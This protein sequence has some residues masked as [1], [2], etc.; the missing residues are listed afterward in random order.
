MEHFVLGTLWLL[1]C[2]GSCCAFVVVHLSFFYFGD[3][4]L[5][6]LWGCFFTLFSHLVSSLTL[7]LVLCSLV[8]ALFIL[9][10]ASNGTFILL[11]NIFLLILL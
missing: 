4:E 7:L 8:G 5:F 11:Y 2:L 6:S 10:G 9:S 1:E 3:L